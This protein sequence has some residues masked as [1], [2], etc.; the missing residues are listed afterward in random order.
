MMFEEGAMPVLETLE[1]QI[2]AQGANTKYG[3]NPPDLG[4]RH[5][6]TLR[7]LVVNV[8]CEGA[9]AEEVERVEAAIQIAAGMLPNHPTL[10][11]H[12]FLESEMVKS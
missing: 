3:F 12:R 1:F 11:L 9:S 6:L 8:H 7:N 4:V 10:A 2:I 5:L